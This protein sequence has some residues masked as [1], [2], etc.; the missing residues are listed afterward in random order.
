[1]V[2]RLGEKSGGTP[3]QAQELLDALQ[4][5]LDGV[6]EFL[7]HAQHLEATLS[8][9]QQTLEVL[10]QLGAGSEGRIEFDLSDCPGA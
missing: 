4:L 10:Q 2:A 9:L 3:A 8:T 6:G 1:M 5:D 7:C